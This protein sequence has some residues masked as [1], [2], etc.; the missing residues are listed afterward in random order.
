MVAKSVH[1]KTSKFKR[2]PNPCGY[3]PPQNIDF[4]AVLFSVVARAKDATGTD[5]LTTDL[6]NLLGHGESN[7]RALVDDDDKATSQDVVD[8]RTLQDLIDEYEGASA[9]LRQVVYEPTTEE[10]KARKKRYDQAYIDLLDGVHLTSK[11]IDKLLAPAHVMDEVRNVLTLHF[12]SLFN[13]HQALKDML[14]ESN[15]RVSTMLDF[16][17]DKIWP[18]VTTQDITSSTSSNT[19]SPDDTKANDVKKDDIQR[20]AIWL[21]LMFKLW[22]WFVLHDFNPVDKMIERTEYQDSRLAVYIG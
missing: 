3:T 12:A 20:S 5:Y 17:F 13:S 7:T 9:G 22:S 6:K 1:I 15:S 11:K 16:Y 8:D 18:D 19:G 4:T 14:R 10:K 21:A 2:L